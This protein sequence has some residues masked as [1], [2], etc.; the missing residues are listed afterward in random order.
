MDFGFAPAAGAGAVSY[1]GATLETST[2]FNLGGGPYT[3]N[4]IDPSDTT[5]VVFGQTI[6]LAP[7]TISY[8][9]GGGVEAITPFTKTFTGSGGVSY[10]E[11]LTSISA[12]TSA[13]NALTLTLFGTISGGAFPAGAGAEMILNANQAGGPGHATNF[14]ATELS[15]VPVPAALPLFAGGLGALGLFGWRRKKRAQASSILN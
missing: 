14:S 15:T 13:A 6:T 2:S 3:I 5:G 1:T 11:T 8:I 9:V 10:T 7:S 4:F 12:T